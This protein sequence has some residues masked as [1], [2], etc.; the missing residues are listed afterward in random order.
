MLQGMND[1]LKLVVERGASDLHIKVGSAPGLRIHG[2][3]VPLNDIPPL[4]K[5]DTERL[6]SSMMTE[7]HKGIFTENNDLDFAYNYSDLYRFRVNAYVQ[8]DSIGAVLRMIPMDIPSIDS[9][10][11][12]EVLKE[13][14]M[15]KRGLI[16]VTGP[17]GSGKSSTLAAMVDHINTNKRCNIVT[18]EDPIEFIHADKKSYIIQRA[19]GKDTKTF[20]TAMSHVLRQDP[21]VILVGEMRDLKTMETAITAAETGHLVMATLHTNSAAE[22]VSR[23][24]DAFPPHQQSQVRSQLSVSLEAVMCQAL[25][26]KQDGTGRVCAIEIMLKIPSVGHLI[27][28]GKTFQLANVIQTNSDLGMQTMD[29]ALRALV[30][31]DLITFETAALYSANPEDFK[32]ITIR[33]RTI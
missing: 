4:S 23:V 20:D 30:E 2:E 10:G 16:L 25:I 28:E 13:I 33:R 24:I 1:L 29:Q 26:P 5:D 22:T 31:Q 18:M 8:R 9:L 19:V 6:V 3:L 21:D 11:L 15:K 12:P 27:R 17:T 7:S 32:K 14:A